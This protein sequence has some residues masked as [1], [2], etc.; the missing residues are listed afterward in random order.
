M[1]ESDEYGW[2]SQFDEV[3]DESVVPYFV[4]RL[5]DI[6]KYG[7]R[8]VSDVSGTSGG[9]GDLE[10]FVIGGVVASEA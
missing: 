1:N 2:S 6:H 3:V 4:K 9:L 7:C 10:Q 8:V 5:L